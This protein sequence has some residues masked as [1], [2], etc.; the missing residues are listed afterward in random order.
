MTFLSTPFR[1]YSHPHF[2][3]SVLHQIWVIDELTV[4]HVEYESRLWFKCAST[5]KMRVGRDSKQ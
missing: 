5:G 3:N 2:P 1:E 4:I